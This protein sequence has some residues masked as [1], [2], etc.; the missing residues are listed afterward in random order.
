MSLDIKTT[1]VKPK[2]FTYANVAK[3]LGEDRPASRYEE[4]TFDLKSTTNFH[5]RPMWDPKHELFGAGRSKIVME[6]WYALTDPRQLY[7]AT[8]TISRNKMFEA[9]DAQLS[10]VEQRKLLGSLD[11][12]QIA[13]LCDFMLP[14]RH[15]DWGANM[16][17][18]EVCRFGSGTAI[19]QPCS[20]AAMDRLGLAQYMSRIGLA[21]DTALETDPEASCLYQTQKQWT[22][23]AH[24]QGL[25]RA[26]ENSFVLEDWF[27]T[28]VAQNLVMD[29]FVYEL[30]YR[31]MDDYFVTHGMQNITLVTEVFRIWYSDHV[32]WVDAVIKRAASESDNNKN[33]IEGWQASWRD[34]VQPAIEE[35]ARA[36]IGDAGDQAVQACVEGYTKRLT[37]L[38]L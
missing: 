37:T 30:F 28:F 15:F 19:T 11:A 32:K 14:L 35:I 36:A 22:E 12:S 9:A 33:L 16:N 2:R 23:A 24:W 3:R 27:E 5:Y 34:Q 6:D 25:R 31:H 4:A 26:L 8:Y 13:L 21:L 17:N 7:Y 38:G 1:V 20:F 18:M 10:F 29:H